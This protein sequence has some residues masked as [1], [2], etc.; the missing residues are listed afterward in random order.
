MKFSKP[1]QI[2]EE[3]KILRAVCAY[4]QTP[5]ILLPIRKPGEGL[6]IELINFYQTLLE[7]LNNHFQ[8]DDEIPAIPPSEENSYLIPANSDVP[9]YDTPK[10]SSQFS[11]NEKKKL[12]GTSKSNSKQR[13]SFISSRLTIPDNMD[14]SIQTLFQAKTSA[15][16]EELLQS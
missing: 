10:T 11:N 5:E 4:Y 14:G 13:M 12:L 7:N 6:P 15:E 16:I 1:R 3:D 9:I 2:F 8:G